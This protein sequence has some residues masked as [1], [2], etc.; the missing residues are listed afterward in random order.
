MF[1]D[2]ISVQEDRREDNV[3]TVKAAIVWGDRRSRGSEPRV[4]LLDT[5]ENPCKFICV[6]IDSAARR[7]VLLGAG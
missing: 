1:E 2:G 6:R 4:A 3:L 7:Q 5:D